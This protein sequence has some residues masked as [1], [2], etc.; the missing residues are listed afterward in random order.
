MNCPKCQT[1][2]D[3]KSQYC[4]NCGSK[5]V[6][7]QPVYSPYA[8]PMQKENERMTMPDILIL[9]FLGINLIGLI[10]QYVIREFVGFGG[11]GRFAFVA[12]TLISAI[13][14]LLPGIAIKHQGG[15]IAGIIMAAIYAIYMI[16]INARW[17]L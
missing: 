9:S 16:I 2:N 7:E 4:K 15:K 6:I 14:M 17:F 8:P 11:A 10:N 12:V 1:P 3:E 13:S 5:L